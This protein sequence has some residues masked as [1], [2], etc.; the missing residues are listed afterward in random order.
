MLFMW[1]TIALF[2]TFFVVLISFMFFFIFSS[3]D[4]KY[5][6]IPKYGINTKNLDCYNIYDL[7]PFD[8]NRLHYF[9]KEKRGK[10]G[11]WM[12]Q[13]SSPNGILLTVETDNETNF[14]S[15]LDIDNDHFSPEDYFGK[16]Y[17][18]SMDKYVDRHKSVKISYIADDARHITTGAYITVFADLSEFQ[19]MTFMIKGENFIDNPEIHMI[20]D[21][22]YEDSIPLGFVKD[23][24]K[25]EITPEWQR[26]TIDLTESAGFLNMKAI[27]AI[28]FHVFEGQGT[29][30]IDDICFYKK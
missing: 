27:L 23:F 28:D 9:N 30:W 29:L 25:N 22:R 24:L 16:D 17:A 14:V 5:E 20:D 11:Y 6:E 3:M 4:S 10:I 12:K 26:I 15:T 7:P 8:S 1:G 19:T 21:S 2:I 18:Q 13:H